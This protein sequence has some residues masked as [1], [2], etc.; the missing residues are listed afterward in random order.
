MKLVSHSAKLLELEAIQSFMNSDGALEVLLTRLKESLNTGDEISKYVK[1][2]AMIEDEHYGLLKKYSS[3]LRS[4]MKASR[5][6]KTD[7][8]AKKF[9]S[10]V[11]FD[12]K[13]YNV[14]SSYVTALNVMHDELVS[15]MNTVSKSRKLIKEECKRKEKECSDA[16]LLADKAKQKYYHLCDD[17][18]KLK[19]SDPNKKSFLKNKTAEQQEDELQRKVDSAD[20]DYKLKVSHSRKIKDE[21]L[22]IHRP[23]HSKKLKN[24]ILELDIAMS[25]QLQKFATWSENLVMNSGVLIAPLQ[26]DKLSMKA[27]ASDIDN[28]LDLYNYLRANMRSSTNKSLVPVDYIAHPSFSKITQP[29]KPFFN[30]SANKST[31]INGPNTIFAPESEIQQS[32]SSKQVP[33]LASNTSSPPF[34]DQSGNPAHAYNSL[35]PASEELKGP[36]LLSLIK[37]SAQPTFSVS[38]EEVIQFAGIDNVPL[39]VKRCIDVIENYGLNIEGLYRTS[40]NKT[41]V[42]SLKESIDSNFANYLL[43]GNNLDPENVLDADIYCTASLLKLYF[44]CLPEPLLTAEYYQAFIDTVKSNNELNI[45]KKL[46]HL[47]YN[48]P[49]G[50][51]FTLR[52]LIF[53]L[54]KV[55]AN[56][57]TNRMSAKSLSIIWGP[58][59]LCDQLMSPQDLSYK[60]KVVEEL[61]LI[62][63]EIF[64]T[65]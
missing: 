55:A 37:V 12:E 19:T 17:L 4:N 40:G 18:E 21:I 36:R 49:D 28:E 61:M 6:M 44:T 57:S 11:E 48:L 34:S 54:N 7:N 24:L 16:I 32:G 47:V 13:L 5:L 52:A 1:R 62:A 31:N 53:H 38:I 25:V 58:A 10:I 20:L 26:S 2:K 29:V 23:M 51:Y 50:A 3:N 41:T 35:D 42:Q 45:A 33:E 63:N 43:I 39:I 64:E 27:L 60:S 59:I 15:L 56:E 8:F 30:S 22:M 65:D 9:D 46:H 14:G